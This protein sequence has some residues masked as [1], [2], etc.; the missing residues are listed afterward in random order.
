MLFA[1]I[2]IEHMPTTTLESI[3]QLKT[4]LWW[5]FAMSVGEKKF[6]KYTEI[7]CFVHIDIHNIVLQVYSKSY[8]LSHAKNYIVVLLI[9]LYSTDHQPPYTLINF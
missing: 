7:R 2:L 4:N 1:K 9:N 3:F 8:P 6:V 5:F